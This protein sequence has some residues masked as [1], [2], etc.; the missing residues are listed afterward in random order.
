MTDETGDGF[1]PA[2]QALT[3]KQRLFVLAMLTDPTGDAAK[4]A[5]TAGYSDTKE[6]A[7][8]RGHEAL[9][10][11]KVKAAAFEVARGQLDA[12][13]PVVAVEGLL[14]IAQRPKHKKHITALLAVLDRVGLPATT[15]HKVTIDRADRSQA[16]VEKRIARALERLEKLGRLPSPLAAALAPPVDAEFKVVDDGK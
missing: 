12:R 15:E 1:G 5:R 9:S 7:K 16:G 4:W 10:N 3:D 14:R 11:P 8:V 6:G 13:G 2:M